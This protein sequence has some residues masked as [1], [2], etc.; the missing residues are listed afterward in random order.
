MT[1][2]ETGHLPTRHRHAEHH[3]RY[4][5]PSSSK[6]LAFAIPDLRFEQSYLNSLQR[7]IQHDDAQGCIQG[8]GKLANRNDAKSKAKSIGIAEHA[9]GTEAGLFSS[10]SLRMD[11]G[12]ILYVTIRNQVRV[13]WKYDML[14]S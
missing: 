5:H 3:D 14:Q 8:D 11:W 4:R 2:F 13:G 12:G 6:K 10:D 7:F 1:S 9:T